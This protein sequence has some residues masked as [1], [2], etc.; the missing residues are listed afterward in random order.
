[1]LLY[2]V[3]CIAL[4][5]AI[6]CIFKHITHSARLMKDIGF[7]FC[8][9]FSFTSFSYGSMGFSHIYFLSFFFFFSFCWLESV[10]V[11]SFNHFIC[12]FL[13]YVLHEALSFHSQNHLKKQKASNQMYCFAS[14]T[15]QKAINI[16][17]IFFTFIAYRQA[18]HYFI[19]FLKRPILDVMSVYLMCFIASEVYKM[20]AM[21]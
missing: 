6:P 16:Q 21:D 12:S 14:L 7:R 8:F 17:N 9:V 18:S 11:H 5:G 19:W 2:A 10:S 3:F 13:S 20:H 1:M 15:F 4:S